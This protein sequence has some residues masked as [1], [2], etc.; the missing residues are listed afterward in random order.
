MGK[1]KLAILSN[2]MTSLIG[3]KLRR[4][5]EIYIPEGFD[6]WVQEIINPASGL[7]LENP[8]AIVVLLDGTEAR[9]WT[10]VK[11]GEEKLSLW[12]QAVHM[13]AEKIDQ[14]PV[15]ISTI[16]IRENRIKAVSERK[17]AMEMAEKWYQF[18]QQVSEKNTNIYVLDLAER[19]YDMGRN[20]FYSEK[21]WYMSSMPYSKE[22]L[23]AVAE[24]IKAVLDSAFK[25]RKKIIALD[26]DNTLWGGVIGEDGLE[27]IELSD[28]KE[29]QRF[30]DFQRQF[31]EMKNRGIV[32]AVTS[33]NNEEDV[34]EV[35]EKHPSMLLKEKDFVSLKI[36]WNN[37]A[38]N[39][40]EISKELNL[41]EGSFIFVDDNPI[42]RETVIGECAEV[43]VPDFPGDST[44]L[45]SF[46]EQI[47]KRYCR[48]LRIV[49]EDLKKTEMYQTE[50][51]RKQDSVASL[52]L[53][54]Y[55]SRLEMEADIHR[56]LP[57]ELERTAQL[58][59]K[60]NQFNLTT[61]RYTAAEI[62]AI[63]KEEGSAIYTVH[64]RDKYGDNGLISVLILKSSGNIIKIDTFLMSCRVMGRKLEDVIINELAAFYK[65]KADKLQGEYIPTAK[66]SPVK[67]LYERLGFALLNESDHKQYELDLK[68]YTKKE[69]GSYKEILFEG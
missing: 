68:E 44:M 4:E 39:I 47:Y 60:T 7:Y 31:L 38:A 40:K 64:S 65:D 30:Y 8:D 9:S 15:F 35:F 23:Q 16:D 33:K 32:L 25:T 17:Y 54:D 14:V 5:Y 43:S 62:S 34:M 69:I 13:L 2:V 41:T 12:K 55:I 26:L 63:E 52:N 56:M 24:E 19:I 29:G 50:A 49:G 46:A 21:M 22:G 1:K 37:K 10:S 36:N 18:V 53:D 45:Q 59:N 66:N 27:G 61:K 20:Q 48:P 3:Q 6:T 11:E 67:D 28:H 51:K 57:E 58:T 42:E